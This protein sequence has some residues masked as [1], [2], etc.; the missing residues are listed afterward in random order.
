M[1]N[2][3][4]TAMAYLLGTSVFYGLLIVVQKKGLE[5]GLAP[6]E[7]S[8]ARSLV[9]SVISLFYFLPQIKCFKCLKK[10]DIFPI[11]LGETLSPIQWL[12]VTGIL[13]GA[14]LLVMRSRGMGIEEKN[15]IDFNG[16]G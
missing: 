14:F 8:F 10:Q 16:S 15:I 5:S 9:V 1:N 4:K 12:G 13:A 2:M 6:M 11:L 3:N 7:F